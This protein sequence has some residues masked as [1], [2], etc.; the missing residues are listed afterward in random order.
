MSSNS[1]PGAAGP[2]TRGAAPVRRFARLRWTARALLWLLFVASAT[3]FV[4]WLS[5]HWLILP[6]IE[7]WRPAIEARAGRM[8]G[9]RVRIGAI[10][11]PS[12][13]W[14]PA[15]ELREVT[16]LDAE[17]RVALTLPR[18]FAALSPRSLLALEP[19]FDQLLIDGASLDV[20]RDRNGRIRVAGLDFAAAP[21]TE[22]DDVVADWFFKQHEFVIRAGAVRWIDDARAAPSLVLGDVEL[23]VRNGLR[24]HDIRLDATPPAGWGERFSLRGRFTQPLFAKSGAWRLWSGTAYADL[25]RADL[26][27]LRRRVTLP[28]EL[29]EGDGALRAWFEV[30]VGQPTSVSADVALR[31]V[32][33]RLDKSVEPLEF[34][35]IE[36]RIDAERIGDRT[37]VAVRGFGFRTGDGLTWPK[38]DLRVA[39]RESES[40][41]VGSGEFDAERLDV[42]VMAEIGT[43]V[44]I[45]AA[46]RQLLADVRPRGTISDLRTRW[47]G[48]LDAPAHYRVKGLLSGLSLSARPS[49]EAD[50]IGRPGLG[51]AAIQLDAN[52]SGG[53]AQI[54]MHAGHLDLPG[55]F[56]ERELPLEH[57]D[58]KLAWKIERPAD[59][60][61]SKVTVRVASATFANADAKGELSATWRSGNGSGVGRG[62]RYP[63]ELELDG[64]LVDG[65]A[66]RTA[67]YLPLGLPEGVRSYVARAVRAGTITSAS[68]RVRGDLW[69]FP[70]HDAKVARDGDFRIAAKVDGLS[71]AYVP[72]EP[73]ST[74][75]SVASSAA[76]DVWP[77]LTG[78][79]AELVVDRST[80][81]IRA[82]KAHFGGIEWSALQGRIPE[83][84][85]N[86]RLDIEG[87]ARGPLAEMLRFVDTTPVGRWTGKA[88]AAAT[89]TG[90]AELK[91]VLAMPLARSAETGVSG[92]LVLAGNDV[93]MTP[94]TPLLASA[95]A[96]VDFSQK[97]FVVSGASARTL[98]GEI[99]FE[100]GSSAGLSGGEGQRFSGRGTVSAEA[101]R[102]SPELGSLARLAGSLSGQTSYRGTLAFVAGRPQIS[103]AS[104]LVGLA[105]DLPAPLAKAAATPLA[106]RIRTGPEDG[107]APPA[108]DAA[109]PVREALQVDLGGLLQAQ[110]VR[111]TS[112]DSAR[113]V[114]GAIRVTEARGDRFVEPMPGDALDL[115]ALPASGVAASVAIKRLDVDAWQAALAHLQGEPARQGTA[116]GAPAPL[117]FDA[118]GGAGYVPD[119]IALRVGELAV[120]GRRLDNVTA[121]LSRAGDLW[122]GNVNADQLDGYVEYRPA[123]R[124]G[125]GAGRVFARLARLALPKGED[126]KVERLLDDPATSIPALDIVVDDFELRGKRLGRLEIEATNRGAGSPDVAREWQLSK[127]NL[128]MP[129]AQFA[130][131]GTWGG[132]AATAASAPRRAA[133]NFTLALA[134]SGALLE[135]LGMGRV[136][137]GGKGSLTGTVSWPGS[138]LSPDYAKMTG[139]VAVAI[140]SGQFLKAG[141]GAARL[142]GV[143]SLQSLPR[144]LSFD[145]RDLFAEG[146]AFDNVVGDVRIGDGQASTNN[147]RMRGAAAAVLMEGSADL[148]R[149]TEDL[150]VV[151]VPEIDAGTASLAFAVINPA[152]GLGTFLAQYF[153]RKPLAA[154]NTREFHVTGPWDDPKVERVERNLVGDAAT[155]GDAAPAAPTPAA[156]VTR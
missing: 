92:S 24:E 54:N 20:R 29:S 83:L 100:G 126:E 49:P 76:R 151:V 154:A 16:I 65:V 39:W 66:A 42:G 141:P 46:V 125:A 101:L 63:G 72:G 50:A 44:P 35:Q 145:F 53:Q 147:L 41:A 75:A 91:L 26:S 137:S 150:R 128:T 85:S 47:D 153:L 132:G 140:D 107:A 143:L 13:G 131:T 27:E 104:N 69:D 64:R 109:A 71:F 122:R 15:I 82:A 110:F 17:Q 6:H 48:P 40:G 90:P 61:A 111:E 62:G 52:E 155:P 130:A 96:R 34:E 121:G 88:L 95:K 117:V 86:A 73:V 120:G 11:A 139:T 119:A 77:P 58:A 2:S 74:T 94:D 105:V 123:R 99:A 43:R 31:A 19:R 51:N 59:G 87:V 23:V 8:I 37:S 133:M 45:G 129:E 108:G 30:R 98:G 152:L 70:F 134:D 118:S 93:R 124:G 89:A 81:E 9:T 149:E 33:L 4:G 138:P 36:G 112:G 18:V 68:V 67:R 144:R 32:T 56:G 55:V 21:G 7:E 103:V 38:G 135:R 113:V 106:L 3:L 84:G 57:L 25:P 116:G 1:P 60:A 136:I 14:V 28:F 5:L 146:F 127:L 142:L 97:G 114:R 148:V 102:Q 115:P 78:G 80:L 10:A 79:S 22:D 156:T 12:S